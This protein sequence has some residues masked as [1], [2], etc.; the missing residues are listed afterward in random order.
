MLQRSYYEVITSRINEPRKFIQII[1]G[2]R[3]VG[4]STLIKQ[5][6]KQTSIPWVHFSADNVAATRT[7]WI[8]D[9]WS[10]ARM[11]LYQREQIISC[12]DAFLNLP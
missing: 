3:Q 4:K 12:G 1:E 9:C 10:T 11:I 8:S 2:P 5:V 6:L 7:A